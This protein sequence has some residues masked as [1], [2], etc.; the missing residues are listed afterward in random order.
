MHYVYDLWIQQWRK[1]RARG[2]VIVVRFADDTVVGFQYESDAKL[3][4]KEL[5]ERLLKV[6]IWN[7]TQ[8]KH[9]SLNSGVLPQKIER[10]EGKENQSTFTFLGFT[11]ICGKQRKDGKFAI[12]R[13]T[14][15]KRLHAK[16]KEI[17]DELRKRMHDPIKQ[18]VNGSKRLLLDIIDISVCLETAMLW[19]ILDT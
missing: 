1:Y 13:H 4:Q 15:K 9:V 3:F 16:V 18:L 17:K 19:V 10:N 8:R 2:E 14:I 11:H 5:Q 6:R 7:C 12:L